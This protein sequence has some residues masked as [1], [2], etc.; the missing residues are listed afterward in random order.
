MSRTGMYNRERRM[1][2]RLTGGILYVSRRSACLR[3]HTTGQEAPPS[4]GA[5]RRAIASR[6]VLMYIPP[7]MSIDWPVM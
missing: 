4:G 6:Y 2:R 3:Y 7:F 1:I 5:R